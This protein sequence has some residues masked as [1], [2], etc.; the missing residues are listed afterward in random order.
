LTSLRATR[1]ISLLRTLAI[2]G[3]LAAL[4]MVTTGAS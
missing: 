4:V 3:I 1:A 2:L